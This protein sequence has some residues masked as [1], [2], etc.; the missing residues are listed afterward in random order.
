MPSTACFLRPIAIVL[1]LLALAASS[2][3]QIKSSS[4]TGSITD[5][6]GAL[7][8]NASVT[9][10]NE[11]TNV[12]IR[13]TTNA[14]GEYTVPYLGAGRYTV[15]ISAAGFQTYR[16]T[17]ITI[18]TGT[19]ARADATLLTGSVAT[20][21]EVQAGAAVLQTESATVQGSVNSNVISLVPNINNNPIYYATLQAG[22]VPD[23]KMY[24]SSRLGVGYGDRQAMSS[25][26]INGGQMGSNDVQLDGVSVLGAAWHET[27]VVPDR[28]T[29][30][31]VRVTTNTFAAD[32]GNGQGL[33]SMITK[34]GTNQYHGTLRYRLRNETLNANGFSNNLRG[35]ARAK[36]R[37][38]EG[39]GTFGGPVI[40]PKVFNGRDK[41]FFFAS[42]SRL[43]HSDPVIYQARVP[44]DL[45]RKGDFSQ[46]LV[47]DNS[48]RPVPV[49]IFDPFSAR[50]YQGSPNV[51]IRNPFPGAVVTNQDPF[52][53]KL[54]QSY[55]VANNPPTDAFSNNNYM[56]RGSAP[57][58]RQSMSS[59][60]DFHPAPANSLYL[61]GGFSKGSISQPNRWGPDAKFGNY[62]YPGVTD[63]ENPYAAVGDTWI[64]DPT[65]VVD[66][67]YGL[68]RIST[69]SSYPVG[70]GFN[71]SEY[72]MPPEVQAL[73]A[74]YGTAPSVGNLGGPIASLNSDGWARKRERQTNHAITGSATKTLS[75]WTLKAGGE[76]RVY[77]G[78]WQDLRYATPNLSMANHNGQLGGLSGGNSSLITDPAL[79]GIGFV[80]AFTGVGGYEI[81]A[82]TSTRPA[83]ASKYI[84]FFTQNDWKATDRLTVNLGLRYEIQPGP[85]ERY[86][87]ISGIDLTRDNP[88]TEGVSFLS[89]Q[90]AFGRIAFPGTETYSR[91]LWDTQWLN[92]SPRVGAAYRLGQS[93]VIRTGYGRVYIPSNTGFNANGLI[94]G[95]GPY[96][97][98]SQ[99]SPYGVAPNGVPVGRFSNSQNTIIIPAPGANQAAALYGNN[100]ASLS[101]DLIPRNYKNGVS[102]QWNFFIERRFKGS[103]LIGAGYVG[104]H[105]SD[106][107]WRGF[108]LAGT[109]SIPDSTLQTWRAG[110]LA[111]N[112]LNDPAN[113]QF[114]NPMPALVGKASGPIGS[115]TVSALNLQKP[116]LSLLNQTVLRNNVVTSYNALQLRAEHAYANGFTAMFNYT[117]SKATGITGGSGG[118]SYAESQ[119]AGIGTS[120]TGGVD[121]RNLQN[122]HG[123]LGYD[124][125]HR[126]VGVFSYD[127]PFG[128][129]K[130][131]DFSNPVL[132]AI[133]G[134]WQIGGVVTLQGGQP[135]GPNCGGL[136]GRCFEVPGQPVEVPAE[137]QRWYDGKTSVTLPDGRIVTPGAFTFLKWNPDRF[138]PPIVQFPNGNYQVDQYWA[139]ATAMYVGGLRTPGFYNTNLT[140]NRQF[141]IVEGVNLEFLAEATNAFNQTN[142]NPN[143]VNAGVGAILV[144][145]PATNAKVG[146]NSNANGGTLGTSFYEPRQI[147]LSLRLRF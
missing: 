90:G 8:P 16:T 66:L 92:I 33:I 104:S 43:D 128:R 125:T 103:W 30:Q 143:A 40:I 101:V 118:S 129:G 142:F 102:D 126:F 4:I 72:G 84:A 1:L 106:L 46:T 145:N 56:F 113:A 10:T 17:G 77:L 52:G 27:T 71:Y 105:G 65:T 58:V 93:L 132:R 135:F 69:N 109:F 39:G 64:V 80:S 117:W 49:Q 68:T 96:S 88:Y 107:A 115:A 44:T 120:S 76:Y 78:N 70:S 67:R 112:G 110:W 51:F 50:P 59:R 75:R 13:V 61:S 38:N 26:R 133:A 89:P 60:I 95:T 123:Y 91:N 32:Q 20:S 139:G 15:V 3:A 35:I 136:N 83:L 74:L 100:N 86:N 63:D 147:S 22:V 73:S 137:L 24:V 11:E 85:T 23:P 108:P 121:F 57:T 25:V 146:Q 130:T 36:Y 122:N 119:A 82:G 31:E 62:V 42:Y 99:A 12:E 9:V 87:R 6:S 97:G 34:S 28:D 116:Y 2:P 55:P 140:V 98:G 7:V 124:I 54:V 48:G 111:S 14:A 45:E 19:I 53:V 131:F 29:L 5:Q 144:A 134:G 79:R 47:A 114:P 41:L 18:G 21:I 94:Y 127:L 81:P 37:L 141:R 138:A